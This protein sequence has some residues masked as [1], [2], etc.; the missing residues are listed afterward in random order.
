MGQAAL[1]LQ[2]R[3]LAVINGLQQALHGGLVDGA[4]ELAGGIVGADDAFAETA[5][6]P[7]QIPDALLRTAADHLLHRILFQPQGFRMGQDLLQGIH[8]IVQAVQLVSTVRRGHRCF[9]TIRFLST[10]L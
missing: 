3:F 1:P 4:D 9:S 10:C 6:Q 5:A 7:F 2:G 8:Q